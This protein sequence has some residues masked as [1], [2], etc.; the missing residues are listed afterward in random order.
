MT[1]SIPRAPMVSVVMAVKNG[2]QIMREAIDSILN[3]TFTDFEFIIINDGSTDETLEVISQYPD[4]R[5]Q[6]FSQEN[7]GLARSLNRG[8]CLATGKYIARQDHDDISLPTRLEKQVAYLE[9]NPKVG[10]LGTAAEIWIGQEPTRRYHDH[11]IDNAQ[12]KIEMLF[13]NPF[14]NTSTIFPRVIIRDIG[15]YDPT[16]EITPLDDF[17]FISRISSKYDIANL[18]ERL[19]IYREFPNSLTSG[20]RGE[21]K[22]FNSSLNLKLAKITSRNIARLLNLPPKDMRCLAWGLL[23]SYEKFRIKNLKYSEIESMLTNACEMLAT[24]NNN[25]KINE[26]YEVKKDHL[27]YLWFVNPGHT[28]WVRKYMYVRKKWL[29]N[30]GRDKYNSHK[31]YFNE[32]IEKYQSTQYWIKVNIRIRLSKIKQWLLRVL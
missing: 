30:D 24:K 16:K 4:S 22:D 17:D 12:L 2:G 6:V 18:A 1:A 19:V 7:Q 27:Q 25:L 31:V 11:A 8:V 21:S 29:N 5:I 10:L 13:D 20:F 14:V 3:Q 26:L 15:L 9:A 28:D 32:I 23:I